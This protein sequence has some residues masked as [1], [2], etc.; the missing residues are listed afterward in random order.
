MT[1][2]QDERRANVSDQPQLEEC[3]GNCRFHRHELNA[4]RR[5]PPTPVFYGMGR[6][7]TLEG[8]QSTPVVMG[9][10]AP[11]PATEWCGEWQPEASEGL[12]S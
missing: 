1:D 5:Y 9:N 10:F 4:C 8:V 7:S 2:M 11:S 6:T 3:C 12:A